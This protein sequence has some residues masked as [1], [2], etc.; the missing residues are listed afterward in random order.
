M[1]TSLISSFLSKAALTIT[2]D[3]TGESVADGIKPV[4]VSIKLT[5]QSMRHMLEDGSTIVDARIIQPTTVTIDGF[6]QDQNAINKV[7][8][9][10]MD[11]S[12]V[13]SVSS[14]GVIVDQMM[15]ESEH[16]KQSPE[17]MSAVPIRLAFKQVITKESKP[18]VFAHASDSSIIDRGMTILNSV[19]QSASDLFSSISKFF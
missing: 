13:Y 6:C 8:T 10:L 17:H 1:A 15:A 5:S 9:I 11:R 14:K 18:V 4:R 16:I 7:N 2:N 12:S 3:L 19:A